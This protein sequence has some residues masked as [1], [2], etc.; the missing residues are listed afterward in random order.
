MT[1]KS[2]WTMQPQRLPV[3]WPTED[4]FP[5]R[6]TMTV[7]AL[8]STVITG[9]AG[10]EQ[11]A[12]ERPLAAITS[13]ENCRWWRKLNRELPRTNYAEIKRPER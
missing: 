6:R 4:I 12:R 9:T 8:P 10:N 11:R 1:Y 13:S 2:R 5:Y 3:H 7:C